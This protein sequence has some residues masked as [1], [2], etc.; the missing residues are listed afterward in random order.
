MS[1]LSDSM[2]VVLADTFTEMMRVLNYHWNTEGRDFF[3][4][5]LLF[6]KIYKELFDAIDEIA[7]HIRALDEYTPCSY[8]RYQ[9]LT[10]IDDDSKIP[11]SSKMI[12]KLLDTNELVLISIRKAIEA[13]KL[14]NDFANENFMAS[15]EEA[16]NKIS[17]MLRATTKT[18]RE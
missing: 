5:H 16:H 14:A 2:K 12:V 10:T 17:W 8:S 4:Y 7:E 9:E 6:E 13:A 15:R 18:S 3:Q 11:T 1:D